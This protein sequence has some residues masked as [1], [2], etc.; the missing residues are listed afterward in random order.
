MLHSKAPLCLLVQDTTGL[1]PA[2]GIFPFL[3][4]GTHQSAPDGGSQ[5]RHLGNVRPGIH[6][7][8]HLCLSQNHPGVNLE[9][10]LDV[11]KPPRVA[12][13]AQDVFPRGRAWT[14]L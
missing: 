5:V 6:R 9:L 4:A 7:G 1:S 3:A 2:L 10:A 12:L 14:Q 11:V 8:R 13:A